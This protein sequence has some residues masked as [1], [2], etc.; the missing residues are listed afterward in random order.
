[1]RENS[2]YRTAIAASRPKKFL[3]AFLDLLTV[4][5]LS[6]V[7]FMIADSI[8]PS[9]P[10][11][12]TVQNQAADAQE[13]LYGMVED[14]GLSA[15][16]EGRL[17][18]SD[19]MAEDY[20]KSAVYARILTLR[21]ADE[22]SRT[23]YEDVVP[24]TKDKDG[25][26]CY[27]VEFKENNN[28]KFL[29]NKEESGIDYYAGTILK[30]VMKYFSMTEGYPTLKDE[31]ALSL[32]E[33]YTNFTAEGLEIQ[34]EILDAYSSGNE[35]ARKD[36]QENYAPYVEKEK[37]FEMAKDRILQDRGI[38]LLA[39]FLFAF[40]LA[41]L[42]LPLLLKRG[43]TLSC[44]VLGLAV[45]SSDGKEIGFA[46]FFIRLVFQCISALFIPFLEAVL[47]FGAEGVFFMEI[48]L[49]SFFN[50]FVAMVVALV[51][52]LVS[53]ILDLIPRKGGHQTLTE[54]LSLTL[55]KDT[56]TF[57]MPEDAVYDKR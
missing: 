3:A 13:S 36:L 42:L 12:K 2:P 31:A 23:V 57:V 49:F 17:L 35:K 29:K 54:L 39:T 41:Y 16:R 27:Y 14:S 43:R 40:L 26:Y 22:I 5:I 7:F 48:N 38:A 20:L 51:Y 18:S 45:V 47:L 24:L 46:S 52:L 56:K 21:P 11:Y 15:K 6:I 10:A 50:L 9:I 55:L 33:A 32:D 34:D 8:L 4:F 28:Q 44:R 25:L 1:M 19:E 37:V 30:N 53:G